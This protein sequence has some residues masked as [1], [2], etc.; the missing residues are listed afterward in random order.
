MRH[1]F[2]IALF[3]LTIQQGF[4]QF[5]DNFSDGNHSTSVEWIGQTDKFEVNGEVLQL[6]APQVTDESYLATSSKGLDNGVWEFYVS[7]DFGTSDDNY[8][9]VYLMSTAS[10]LLGSLNGYFVLIGRSEDEISLY[11]QD[12][13]DEQVLIDGVDKTIAVD[14]VNVRIRIT[15]DASGNWELFQDL[16]GRTT[17][18]SAGTA[19]DNTYRFTNYFGVRCTYSST[20]HDL[21]FFDDFS[22]TG[23]PIVDTEPPTI[24]SIVVTDANT[25]VV[26]FS[27]EL[28]PATVQEEDFSINQNI[29]VS[30]VSLLGSAVTL[31][32]SDLTNGLNNQLSVSNVSDGEGNVITAASSIQFTYLVFSTAN[33][34]DVQI[35]EFLSDPGEDSN[36]PNA[37]FV[38][39]FNNSDNYFNLEEWQLLDAASSSSQIP[40]YALEPGG[41]VIICKDDFESD[42]QAYGDV[43]GLSSFPSF[44]NTDDVITL[45]DDQDVVID[46][47]VYGS[48]IAD[49]GVSNEQVN[50]KLVCSGDFNFKPS[51]SNTSGTPGAENSVLM[52]MPDNFA[53]KLSEAQAFSPDSIRV[54]FNE[55]IDK[56]TVDLADFTISNGISLTEILLQD[57]YPQSAFFKVGNVLT[58]NETYTV[59][60]MGVS[61]CSG[62]ITTS[63]SVD[64]VLGIT[65][66]DNDILLSEVL[67]NPHTGSFDFVEIYNPSATEHFELRGWQLARLDADGEIDDPTSLADEGL[68][69]TPGAFLVFSEAII[70]YS[71]PSPNVWME[72]AV[73]SY[74]DDKGSV[75]L[76]NPSEEI[77]QRFDYLDDYHYDLLKDDEGVSLERVS[78]DN[79]AN[80]PNN[81]RSA[82]ST[83]GFATPGAM[84][85]QSA[86][87]TESSGSL[88]IEP[89]VFLPGNAGTG[90]DF[91]TINY[92][93]P[94]GGKFANV[95]IYDQAGRPIKEL[96]NGTSLSTSGFFRWDGVSDNGVM[97]RMGYYIV[98]FETYDGNG[99]IDV[100]RE[101][102]V[103]GR[104]F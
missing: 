54:D 100:M 13:T 84:N 70:D 35:N 75:L 83:A 41:Y 14:P 85:S 9:R 36:L 46:E 31:T 81:W 101:T 58:E 97:A 1:S 93:F 20:R 59:S 69:I 48:D 11:R 98:M 102:V 17:F 40:E 96:A 64:F 65:P 4:A 39:L 91:T 6:N 53:P 60:V 92:N 73:P 8:S 26:T 30:N 3:T 103:V 95:M 56:T 50:P 47:V 7:M 79:P 51:L 94:S 61:D 57:E 49:E 42:F 27:E 71:L 25:V 45:T 87:I 23:T 21:F 76:L 99:N 72:V 22:V 2:I 82:A 68:V 80:D 18:V 62:N 63:S 44:N 34:R 67:F 38:E 86:L 43:I 66:E 5:E 19:S 16:S 37:D 74:S 24:E 90:R 77:V 12:G 10:N 104:D 28:D 15:R 78:Y 32:V 52:I 55:F 89:K 88:S 29:T 33:F